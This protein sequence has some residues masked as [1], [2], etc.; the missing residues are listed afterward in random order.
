MTTVACNLHWMAADSKVSIDEEE[1]NFQTQKLFRIGDSI[2][3]ICGDGNCWRFIGWA[4]AG[5]KKEDRPLFFPGE[6]LTKGEFSVLELAPDGIF[7]WDQNLFRIPVNGS[8]YAVGTGAMLATYC[9]RRNGL[10][11]EA[12]VKEAS[13]VDDHTDDRITIMRLKP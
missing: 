10:P 1:V 6:A 4:L 5:F 13:T 9:M 12:A 11:P 7:V 3:G 2:F 8:N